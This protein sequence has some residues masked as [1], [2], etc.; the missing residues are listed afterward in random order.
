MR[1]RQSGFF[2][3][4]ATIA[5][6]I[7]GIL[8][9]LYMRQQVHETRIQRAEN[10][11][12]ALRIIGNGVESFIVEHHDNIDKALNG[13]P[14]VT[15]ARAGE[16]T[17]VP[18]SRT[19]DVRFG[20]VLQMRI[21]GHTGPPSAAAIIRMTRLPGVGD[22]PPLPGANYVVRIF[23]DVNN[24]NIR[25][26]VH[27]DRTLRTTYGP[28][29]D[30]DMLGTAVRKIGPNGGLSRDDSGRF[31]FPLTPP[32]DTTLQ[33]TLPSTSD[34]PGLLAVRAGYSLSPLNRYLRRDGTDAMTGPLRMGGKDIVGAGNIRLDGNLE[35]PTGT[36]KAKTLDAQE[37]VAAR[38]NALVGGEAARRRANA[39]N[40][41]DAPGWVIAG[42]GIASGQVVAGTDA[43]MLAD[44]RRQGDGIVAGSKGVWSYGDLR[45]KGDIQSEGGNIRAERRRAGN[46]TGNVI[47]DGSV[48]GGTLHS[49]GTVTASGNLISQGG[50]LQL[51]DFRAEANT[52]CSGM[53]GGIAVNRAGRVV[54]CQSGRWQI[55][56]KTET[57][58]V[59]RPVKWSYREWDLSGTNDSGVRNHRFG[60]AKV[61][62]LLSNQHFNP[63]SQHPSISPR[64]LRFDGREYIVDVPHE[65]RAALPRMTVACLYTDTPS[66]AY[67]ARYGGYKTYLQPIA[68]G[69][70]D[71][72]AARSFVQANPPTTEY[73]SFTYDRFRF[74]SGDAG[75]HYKLGDWDHCIVDGSYGNSWPGWELD[76]YPP[77]TY[78]ENTE[79]LFR[80]KKRDGRAICWRTRI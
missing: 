32:G 48:T 54:S 18:L 1:N 43:Q 10:I 62:R 61:C 45:A 26:V 53:E 33:N 19:T 4:G 79:W 57:Y 52:S 56:L 14:G 27:L 2:L 60:N 24:P 16:L 80:V 70:F 76:L 66:A 22:R 72:A 77:Q 34:T 55:S 23:R 28:D 9:T 38:R 12:S 74:L 31:T 44:V 37:D 59:D 65:V 11:G 36:L 29:P 68:S 20:H 39:V 41:G 3:I 42:K 51:K 25:A 67:A 46:N 40:G 7:A 73:R 69:S 75:Y 30:W 8:L 71:G 6:A 49:R 58:Y 17:N 47:A 35:S 63:A 13:V 5:V 64:Y 50:A 78:Y 21:D 15:L